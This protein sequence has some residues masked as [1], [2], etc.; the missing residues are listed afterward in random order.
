MAL[1]LARISQWFDRVSTP[2]LIALLVALGLS[3]RAWFAITRYKDAYYGDESFGVARALALGRGFA[4]PFKIGQGPTAHLLPISPSIAGAVYSVFGVNSVTSE[5]LL[6]CWASLLVV[7]TAV[8]LFRAFGHLGS[9]SA[10]RLLALAGVCLL[11]IYTANEVFDFGRWDNGLATFLSALFLERLL[12]LEGRPRLSMTAVAGMAFLAALTF[13][14]NPASGIAVYVCAAAFCLRNFHLR[15]TL[16]AAGLATLAL[17]L[18][19]VPWM[20]RNEAVMGAPILLRSNLGLELALSQFPGNQDSSV[21]PVA[22]FIS[23]YRQIHPLSSDANFRVMLAA[24]GE[25]AYSQQ[26]KESTEAWMKAHPVTALLTM[27]QH[28]RQFLVPDAYL[29]GLDKAFQDVNWRVGYKDLLRCWLV[30]FAG[31]LALVSI[32]RAWLLR[33]SKWVYPALLLLLPALLLSPFQPMP[34]YM[35]LLYPLQVFC[36]ADIVTWL[37]RRKIAGLGQDQQSSITAAP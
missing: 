31:L 4:D 9:S 26:L 32:A 13:F 18:F 23:R 1:V 20:L 22:R 24:G 17:A 21:T 35:Y 12:A 5:T 16:A 36:A 29:F 30:D 10:A 28:A 15:K 33:R 19:L 27:A 2:R 25:V 37:G 7:G 34:R 3:K 11:P 8:A 6:I 14:V